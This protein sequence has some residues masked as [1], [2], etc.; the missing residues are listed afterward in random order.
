[1]PL[2]RPPSEAY[3]LI[4]QITRGCSWNRCAFCEMY[5]SKKFGIKKLDDILS[6]IKRAAHYDNSIRKVFLADGD[7]MVL[8][9]NKL[10][11]ILQALNDAF[12][13]L[14]RISAYAR[15]KDIAA[16]SNAELQQLHEAGLK[17]L[18]VGVETGND[19][20]LRRINKGETAASTQKGLLKAK[21]AGI[22][23]SVMILNGLGGKQY[24]QAHAIDS[25][26]LLNMVQPDYFSLL[27]LSFPFGEEHY[28]KRFDGEYI[29]MNIVEL[30]EET[31]Q[32]LLHTE[33]QQSVF[34]SDHAS[35]YLVLKGILGADKQKVLTQIDLALQNPAL[36]NL[37][38]EWQRGL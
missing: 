2:F 22:K 21:Q 28:K 17:M 3:S 9:F 29:P 37:R 33:L 20:L 5:S 27:V 6:E 11:P 14:T 34:R 16:K 24:S 8:S 23:S 31:R 19:D 4:I 36:A 26:K 30:I 7:A 10:M 13:K 35:N 12:P 38:K 25:A 32:M 1:M 18:Y 15:P